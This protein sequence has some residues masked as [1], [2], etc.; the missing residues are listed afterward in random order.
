MKE[1]INKTERQPT[2]WEKVFAND[3]ANKSLLSKMYK[4]LI[5]VKVL[6]A[7]SCP[8]LCDPMD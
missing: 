2:V 8:T 7:Q 6:T 5:Q 4:E 3:S 1:T